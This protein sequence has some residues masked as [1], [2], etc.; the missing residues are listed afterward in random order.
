MKIMKIMKIMDFHANPVMFT[1]SHG[2]HGPMRLMGISEKS[3]SLGKVA[4][5]AKT[6]GKLGEIGPGNRVLPY[7]SAA[8]EFPGHSFFPISVTEVNLSK[9]VVVSRF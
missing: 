6:Y 3:M 8:R 5:S 4:N 2:I 9:Y 7:I 1:I